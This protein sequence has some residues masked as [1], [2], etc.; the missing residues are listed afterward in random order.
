MRGLQPLLDR[1]VREGHVCTEVRSWNESTDVLISL[2]CS[3]MGMLRANRLRLPRNRKILMVMEPLVTAPALTS[4]RMVQGFG[5]IFA[6]SP[7]WAR[8]LGGQSFLW[9][10]AVSPDRVDPVG[11]RYAATLINADKRSAA[12]HSLYGFRRSVI[13]EFDRHGVPLAVIG[14]GWRDPSYRRVDKGVRACAKSIMFA[15]VPNVAEAFSDLRLEPKWPLGVVHSKR[16]ALT[17]APV[18]VVIENSA[19]YVS[20]KLF[21]VMRCGIPAVYVGPALGNFGI[22]SAVVL[23]VR[24]DPAEV[25]EAIRDTDEETFRSIADTASTWLAGPQGQLHAYSVVLD[26]LGTRISE[27]L[28]TT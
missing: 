3:A 20:E 17:L 7:L 27:A 24:P 22:P 10:Q 15:Q 14:H 9:P 5:Q 21:D 4:G 16:Q 23:Q 19:D 25:L 26:S 6:A 11:S 28:R 1:L 8:Q 18:S 2:D 13:R 12:R